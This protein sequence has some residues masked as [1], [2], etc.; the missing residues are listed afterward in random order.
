[1]PP[2]APTSSKIELPELRLQTVEVFLI[3]DSPLICHAFSQ[4]AREAML[5][6]QMKK[7]GGGREAKDPL[8]DFQHSL[9]EMVEGGFGF[10][11]VAFKTAAVTACTSVACAA[12][13]PS[14]SA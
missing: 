5:D 4:K 1:M 2:K 7:A 6:K 3:G 8:S 12:P 14:R 9:Y 10:P 11:S 13:A